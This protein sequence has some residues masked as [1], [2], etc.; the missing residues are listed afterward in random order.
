M[1]ALVQL[2]QMFTEMLDKQKEGSA[3]VL[4]LEAKRQ[5]QDGR[6][7]RADRIERRSVEILER[8]LSEKSDLPKV[9]LLILFFADLIISAKFL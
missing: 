3:K 1:E 4:V 9:I 6:W 7:K 5:D 8:K 2:E